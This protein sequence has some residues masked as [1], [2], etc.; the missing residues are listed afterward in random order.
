[1]K[2]NAK[3][4]IGRVEIGGVIVLEDA[5]VEGDFEYTPG[6]PGVR[7][8]SNGDPGYPPT[9]AEAK[10]MG[11]IDNLDELMAEA[12]Y[13]GYE[14]LIGRD[15]L[16]AAIGKAMESEKVYESMVTAVE[17]EAESECP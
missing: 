13:G 9:H 7:T 4:N 17:A 11:K 3:V 12:E 5:E 15:E 6:D 2:V 1:M 14:K 16:A 8:F 10:W